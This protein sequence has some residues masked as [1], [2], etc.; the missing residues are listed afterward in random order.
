M[1]RDGFVEAITN[2][3]VAENC[4]GFT[5]VPNPEQAHYRHTYFTDGVQ[6]SCFSRRDQGAV[7]AT[8]RLRVSVRERD[9]ERRSY[10]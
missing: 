1:R 10:R 2:D 5:R 8:S 3:I 6:N 4:P 9:K 7:L